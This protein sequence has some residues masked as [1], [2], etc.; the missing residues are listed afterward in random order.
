MTL[1]SPQQLRYLTALAEHGHFGRA[2]EAC[3]VTQ[4]T[5]S[6]GILALERQLDAA[7]FEGGATAP[8]L[9]SLPPGHRLAAPGR[10]GRRAGGDGTCVAAHAC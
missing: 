8:L 10:A 4:S 1:P 6:A 9:L 5:L 2:A 3:A 7:L